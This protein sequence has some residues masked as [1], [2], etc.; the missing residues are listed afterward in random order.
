[1]VA[2]PPCPLP[3]APC[4]CPTTLL[5]SIHYSAKARLLHYFGITTP[6]GNHCDITRGRFFVF[7]FG[8]GRKSAQERS[9][10]FTVLGEG[11]VERSVPLS[12]TWWCVSWCVY[13]GVLSRCVCVSCCVCISVLLHG[14]GGVG[15]R[16][17]EMPC[18]FSNRM[19]RYARV[20]Y[21]KLLPLKKKKEKP[22]AV[23]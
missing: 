17:R 5:R 13:H 21:V 9:H 4:P 6:L 12:L 3:L 8:V 18:L 23:S 10:I 15:S 14:G 7:Y 22:L 11:R 1:M 2:P 20:C 19:L 16:V